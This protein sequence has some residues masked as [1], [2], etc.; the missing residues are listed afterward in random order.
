MTDT[1]SP[2]KRSQL[3]SRIKAQNTTPE[4]YIKTL[5]HAAGLRFKSHDK[6]LPGCPDLTFT[7]AKVVVLINGDFW[8][9]WRYP[10][11]S[12]KLPDFWREKI[13]GNRQRDVRNLNKLCRLGWSVL[14]IWEHQVEEDAVGCVRRI[15][16]RVGESHVDWPRVEAKYASLPP[17]KRRNRLPKA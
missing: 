1:M 10:V 15:V 6:T 13:A 14:R 2:L 8:H 16:A 11:W 5:L 3:M 7:R 9:G 12:H 17:L 4:R